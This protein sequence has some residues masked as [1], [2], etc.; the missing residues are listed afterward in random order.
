MKLRGIVRLAAAAATATA[1]LVGGLAAPSSAAAGDDLGDI[2]FPGAALVFEE[3]VY[4]ATAPTKGC[5]GIDT[6]KAVADK[7]GW[8]FDKPEGRW[9][10]LQ[11]I[12][13]FVKNGGQSYDDLVVLVLDDE[14]VYTFVETDPTALAKRLTANALANTKAEKLPL[15]TGP[16]PAGVSGSLADGG[17]WLKTPAGWALAVGVALTDPLQEGTFN[18]VRACAAAAEPSSPASPSPVVPSSP[19]PGAGPQLPV[20]GTNVWVLTGAGAALVAAGAF[21]FVAYRRRQRVKFVA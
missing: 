18:L 7:D 2:D 8:L 15:P 11:Y 19:A 9:T 13:L 10:D 12:F 1:L 20:T 4:A 17:G 16:A 6:G 3:P 5:A 21:L 14:G